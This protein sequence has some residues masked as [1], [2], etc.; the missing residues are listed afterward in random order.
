MWGKIMIQC[1]GYDY[2]AYMDYMDLAVTAPE[3][4]V[5]QTIE[6]PEIWDATALIMTSL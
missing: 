2:T 4:T 1:I 5:E 3:Q 6:T